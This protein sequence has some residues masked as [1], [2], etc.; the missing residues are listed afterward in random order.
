MCRIRIEFHP[1]FADQFA[2]LVND[3]DTLE[4]A[5][6]VNGLVSALET[7]GHVIEDTDIS[8]P[9]VIARYD[10]HTLRRTPPNEI[11]PYADHPPVIRIFYAWFADLA[12]YTE[13][14]VVFEMGDKSLSATPNQWYPLIVNRIE[15][16]TI[17]NWEREHPTH[18][19][20]IK[21]TR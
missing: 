14:P 15:A 18:R 11:C 3:I 9:I 6:E 1:T 12:D 21:R 20:R 17:P 13:F 10:I 19:A 4:V 8:H 5:G 7:Y 16:Q 2:R